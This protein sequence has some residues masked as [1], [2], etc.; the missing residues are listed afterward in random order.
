LLG[1]FVING[2]AVDWP[3]QI[4]SHATHSGFAEITVVFAHYLLQ[5]I[6]DIRFQQIPFVLQQATH[7]L[8]DDGSRQAFRRYVA[9]IH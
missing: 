9:C 3:H 2:I 6:Q 7:N 5:G 8:L 1:T 4:G